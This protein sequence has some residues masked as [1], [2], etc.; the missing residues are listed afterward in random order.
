[1]RTVKVLELRPSLSRYRCFGPVRCL[2]ERCS[3]H[4][5]ERKYFVLV[6]SSIKPI[7]MPLLRA[8]SRTAQINSIRWRSWSTDRWA[9]VQLCSSFYHTAE[10]LTIWCETL[11]SPAVETLDYEFHGGSSNPGMIPSYIVILSTYVQAVCRHNQNV[12]GPGHEFSPVETKRLIFC[13]NSNNEWNK[14]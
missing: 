9:Q 14:N 2:L 4:H 13:R 11:K 12:L 10:Y 1:M 6:Y 3:K 7:R 8:V 5:H